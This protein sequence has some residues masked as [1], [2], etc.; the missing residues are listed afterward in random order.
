M[1]LYSDVRPGF[2][3]YSIC[4]TQL[5][6]AFRSPA[7]TYLRLDFFLNLALVLFMPTKSANVHALSALVSAVQLVFALVSADDT[8]DTTI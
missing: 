5:R 8:R 2:G 7:G 6:T 3:A 1:D 4:P